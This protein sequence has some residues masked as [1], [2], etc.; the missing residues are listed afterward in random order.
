M[1]GNS[2]FRINF[3]ALNLG[4]FRTPRRLQDGRTLLGNI[5]MDSGHAVHVL[6]LRF[7]IMIIQMVFPYVRFL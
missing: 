4:V 7:M 6:A 3:K 2:I 1:K 5:K